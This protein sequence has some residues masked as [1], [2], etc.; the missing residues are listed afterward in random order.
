MQLA[1]GLWDHTALFST[2]LWQPGRVWLTPVASESQV[3]GPSLSTNYH[4]QPAALTKTAS[5]GGKLIW[6]LTIQPFSCRLPPSS[7]LSSPSLLPILLS[8]HSSSHLL[9]SSSSS[10]VLSASISSPL[11]LIFFTFSFHSPLFCF[12]SYSPLWHNCSPSFSFPPPLL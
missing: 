12:P 11:L 10:T 9:F 4:Q 8:C 1:L 7:L 5:E 2:F 6:Q 3:Q